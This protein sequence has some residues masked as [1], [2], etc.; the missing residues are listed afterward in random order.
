[1][2]LLKKMLPPVGSIIA[3]SRG[4]DVI[5]DVLIGKVLAVSPDRLKCLIKRLDGYGWVFQEIGLINFK[6]WT[7]ID[8]IKLGEYVW[9][10]DVTHGDFTVVEYEGIYSD[11]EDLIK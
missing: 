3:T 10:I 4:C 6:L 2:I 8:S 9:H 11:L 5:G 7:G 1:M